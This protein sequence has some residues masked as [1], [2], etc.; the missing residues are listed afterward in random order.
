MN[1]EFW[2]ECKSQHERF[3]PYYEKMSDLLMEAENCYW[4]SPVKCSQLL[5][6]AAKEI[7]Q[8]YNHFFELD[9]A[10]EA[11]LTEMLCYSGD[12][13]HDKKVSKF[14][15]AVSDQQRNQLNQIRV[16]GEECVFL[17]ANPEHRDAQ[18]DKLYLNV[19]KM[20]IA[21]M[22]C[23]KHLLLLVEERVD[24]DE[25]E[26]DEDKVPGEPPRKPVP[27]KQ[28]FWKKFKKK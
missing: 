21:M 4:E 28:S 1:F 3:R 10:E 18:A 14:L 17:E 16:L 12:D 25:L 6:I 15:C 8:V 2:K 22:D 20:M 13:E 19:K 24:E 26:F 9:F 11:S 7:C 5:Q 27:Q 23:L